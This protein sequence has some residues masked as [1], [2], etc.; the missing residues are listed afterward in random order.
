MHI[1]V[2]S[3][4]PQVLLPGRYE[5]IKQ[6][7]ED[8]GHRLTGL[9]IRSLVKKPDY[10][11]MYEAQWGV[12]MTEIAGQPTSLRF[13]R[14]IH[15]AVF[16]NQRQCWLWCRRQELHG[17]LCSIHEVGTDLLMTDNES[18]EL[19]PG[20]GEPEQMVRL[21]HQLVAANGRQE[22]L[23]WDT[24]HTRRNAW[25]GTWPWHRAM[26][27]MVRIIH[28]Q[29]HRNNIQGFDSASRGSNSGAVRDVKML[30]EQ[31]V[32]APIVVEVAVPNLVVP[33][34]GWHRAMKINDLTRL[35]IN[36]ADHAERHLR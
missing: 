36:Y 27:S 29:P 21:A 14:Q 12:N 7:V 32:K 25:F 34:I 35:I 13:P 5:Q 3:F 19:H 1:S 8:A 24:W 11:D 4:L 28:L 17:G 26:A 9:P 33:I 20:L 30:L 6:I 22:V 23:T 16:P 18:L 15:W 10:F 31:G 2:G